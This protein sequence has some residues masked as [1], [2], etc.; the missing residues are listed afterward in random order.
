MARAWDR[1]GGEIERLAMLSL[2]LTQAI[3]GGLSVKG[4]RQ[5]L[6]IVEHYLSEAIHKLH[7]LLH[8]TVNHIRYVYPT[9]TKYVLPTLGRVAHSVAV[10]LPR[11]LD[12]L[13]TREKAL[14]HEVDVTIPRDIAHL[15]DQTKA[16]EDHAIGLFRWIRAHPTAAASTAF[17]GAVA[18]A[19]QALGLSWTR[20]N[21]ARSFWRNHTCSAWDDIGKILGL[22][23][24]TA[25]LTNICDILP[26]LEEGFGAVEGEIVRLLTVVPLGDCEQLPKGWATLDV[27]NAPLPPTQALGQIAA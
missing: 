16:V 2:L 6:A 3:Y 7:G 12:R 19:L 1:I 8:V 23:I 14:A 15:R 10:D 18:I 27:T 20:C 9:V 21:N 25:L 17:A 22:L 4:R 24:D 13:R 11:E 26:P 5:L